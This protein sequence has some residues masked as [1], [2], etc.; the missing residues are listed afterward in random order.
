MAR[1]DGWTSPSELADYAYCPRSHWYGQHPP[2]A[3]SSAAASDRSDAGVRYHRRVLTAERRRAERG[4]A[5]WA[6]VVLG[7]GLVA[8]GVLWVLRYSR[9]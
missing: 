7:A 2:N 8:L 4:G 5:Y 1:D 6:G 9:F 3:G